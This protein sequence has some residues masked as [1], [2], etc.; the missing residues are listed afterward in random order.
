LRV[1]KL[2]RDLVG[3][4]ALPRAVQKQV[5]PDGWG[6][7]VVE[8][9]ARHGVDP[10]MM[11]AIMRQES[12]FDP[13]A[14]SN[15]QAMGLTQVVPP[16]A[17]G[18]A[19]RL[20]YDDFALRD[21]YKPAVSLEFGTWFMA[22]LMEEFKG[23]PFPALAAYNAGGGTVTRWLQRFGDDPDVMV[24]LVPFA[25]TQTYL[26]IVYDNYRHYQLLYGA[27]ANP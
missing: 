2:E 19:A 11:L 7:L 3:L 14:Q 13:R 18:I 9:S 8:Q 15:A 12:S 10:L 25:E 22:Q 6:D 24:E 5:Y 1:G 16:T 17:R 20:G 26:R 21:L 23:R 4:N 27:E